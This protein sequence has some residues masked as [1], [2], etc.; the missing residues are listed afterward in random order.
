MLVSRAALWF[1]VA[2]WRIC[3]LASANSSILC[4]LASSDFQAQYNPSGSKFERMTSPQARLKGL[5]LRCQIAT[6]LVFRSQEV[7][8]VEFNSWHIV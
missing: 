1:G 5:C 3:G 2:D 4:W 7:Q 8:G 6:A